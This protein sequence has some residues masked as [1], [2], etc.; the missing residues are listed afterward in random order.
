MVSEFLPLSR[1]RM[2]HF[3]QRNRIIAGLSLGVL[4]VEA[5]T[6]S[7]ALITARLAVEQGREVFAVPG[8]LMSPVSAGCNQLI[9][10]GAALVTCPEQIVAELQSLLGFHM[11]HGL[12]KPSIPRQTRD[13]G[14]YWLEEKIGHGVFTVDQLSASCRRSVSEIT[15]ALVE[16]EMAGIVTQNEYGYQRVK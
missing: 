8:S 5:S 4:V 16:L 14:Q 7:S 11:E 6:R 3:P 10:D 15:S 12:P 1:P 9:R 13:N 2:T